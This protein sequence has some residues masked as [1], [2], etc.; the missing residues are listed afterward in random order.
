MSTEEQKIK[1]SII[2]KNLTLALTVASTLL[3]SQ[4]ALANPI[5]IMTVTCSGDPTTNKIL[6]KE[7]HCHES[8]KPSDHWQVSS[9]EHLH[10][11]FS[12]DGYALKTTPIILHS[13]KVSCGRIPSAAFPNVIGFSCHNISGGFFALP[14]NIG[15]SNFTCLDQPLVPVKFIK[16][17]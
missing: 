16:Q 3:V 6:T 8:V 9:I 10:I 13:D 17:K 12:C 15:W 1:G 5:G 4:A 7:G 14:H 2:M 11:W